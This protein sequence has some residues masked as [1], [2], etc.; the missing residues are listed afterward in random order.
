M[1]AKIEIRTTTSSTSIRVKPAVGVLLEGIILSEAHHDG[2]VRIVACE[3]STQR[4]VFVTDLP[5]VGCHVLRIVLEIGTIPT[6]PGEAIE[7]RHIFRFLQQ[8]FM[9]KEKTSLQGNEDTG[10]NK[11]RRSIPSKLQILDLHK[12]IKKLLKLLLER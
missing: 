8:S 7:A 6:Q 10:K 5:G 1:P 2:A 3:R 4:I 9:K 11:P 12:M